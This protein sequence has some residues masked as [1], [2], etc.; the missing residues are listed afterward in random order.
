MTDPADDLSEVLAPQP[1]ASS[2]ALRDALLRATERRLVRGRWARR[3]TRV[4]AVAAVFFVGGAAGWLAR[5]ER[6]RVVEV[7]GET[8]TVAVPVPVPVLVPQPGVDT[9][10]SPG[11]PGT[12]LAAGEAELRAEQANEPAEAAKLYRAAGDAFLRDQDY[13]NATR[14]YHLYLARGGDSALSVNR[15]DSWLLTSLKNAAF[16]EKTNVPKIDG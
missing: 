5:P 11:T 10:G 14:C 4:A 1:G 2:P 15:D 16:K 6:Q 13:T 3:L 7:A 12:L 8:R 9:L